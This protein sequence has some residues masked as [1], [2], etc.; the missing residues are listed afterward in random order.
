MTAQHTPESR[1]ILDM[2]YINS[3]PHPFMGRLLGGWWPIYDFEVETGLVRIDV[4]GKL[5]IKGLAEFSI[6][7]DGLLVDRS[8]E[9]F[10]SDA[11]DDERTPIDQSNGAA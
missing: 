9:A 7:R 5:D 1:D 2:D 3:L 11:N 4:C 6:I 8:V 10:Y